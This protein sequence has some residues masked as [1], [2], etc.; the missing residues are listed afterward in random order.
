MPER[1]GRTETLHAGRPLVVGAVTLLPIER[2]VVRSV[3]G[4]THLWFSAT[5][6]PYALVVRDADGVRAVGIGAAA[7]PLEELR[8]R[9][10]GL[11]AMLAPRSRPP[12][13]QV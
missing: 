5:K 9:I 8:E 1:G 12:S 7:V 2:V 4:G 13:A 11:E 10:P 3:P 6:E